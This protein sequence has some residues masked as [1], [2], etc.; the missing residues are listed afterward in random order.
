MVIKQDHLSQETSLSYY[1][2]DVYDVRG[3]PGATAARLCL[4][5]APVGTL[6]GASDPAE[7]ASTATVPEDTMVIQISSKALV[8]ETTAMAAIKELLDDAGLLPDNDGLRGTL[9]PRS[10]PYSSRMLL[11]WLPKEW[12]NS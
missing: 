4:S 6:L 7:M 12:P 10:F 1:E 8:S 9:P 2:E 5:P 11:G 3:C